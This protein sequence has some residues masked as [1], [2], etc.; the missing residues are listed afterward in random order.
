MQH[1]RSRP[2]LLVSV[3]LLVGV[4]AAHAAPP[5]GDVACRGLIALDRRLATLDR[6]F[7][8]LNPADPPEILAPKQKDLLKLMRADAVSLR[9]VLTQTGKPL[10]NEDADKGLPEF[11]AKA[12]A[13]VSWFDKPDAELT[14]DQRQQVTDAVGE[15]R[16]GVGQ[17]CDYYA[18]H[19]P[20]T[21]PEG[22]NGDPYPPGH[23]GFGDYSPE[24]Q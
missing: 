16:F 4:P 2:F 3:A 12:A 7:G 9:K 21:D 17:S 14:D 10:G 13:F 24:H 18:P 8:E 15:Y 20:E 6:Q 19:D 11:L 22:K 1:V 5:D 23:N